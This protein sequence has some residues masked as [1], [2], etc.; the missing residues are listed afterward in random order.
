MGTYSMFNYGNSLSWNNFYVTNTHVKTICLVHVF[1][2]N[3]RQHVQKLCSFDK[4]KRMTAHSDNFQR[5]NPG[6]Q[7]FPSDSYE[8]K[9]FNRY[10]VV[11]ICFKMI[12]SDSS[13]YIII[14]CVLFTQGLWQNIRIHTSLTFIDSTLQAVF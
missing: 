8:V 9:I 1:V 14:L 11:Q 6:R 10:N 7:Y 2:Y 5:T 12:R 3:Q 13:R 4:H